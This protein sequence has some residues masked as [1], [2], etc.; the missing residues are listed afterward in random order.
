ML[1]VELWMCSLEKNKGIDDLRS[2]SCSRH[3]PLI[4][5]LI[6]A[7][8]AFDKVKNSSYFIPGKFLFEGGHFRVI[9]RVAAIAHNTHKKRVGMMPCVTGIVMRWRRK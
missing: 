7:P 1:N 9:G 4:L 3:P 6:L 8:F 2:V 5:T